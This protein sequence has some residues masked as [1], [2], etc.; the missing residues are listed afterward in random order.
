MGSKILV[1]RQTIAA[2]LA[3]KYAQ[4][5]ASRCNV[6]AW[7]NCCRHLDGDGDGDGVKL[8]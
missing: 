7:G 3:L 5:L 1:M 4:R 8:R 2:P 6:E